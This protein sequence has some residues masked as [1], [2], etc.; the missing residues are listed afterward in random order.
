MQ[1]EA[2]FSFK[3]RLQDFLR[4]HQQGSSPLA[5]FFSGRP[6]VKDAMEAL[7]VPHLE[8]GLIHLNGRSVSFQ[9]PLTH[10]ALLEVIPVDWKAPSTGSQLQTAL[11]DPLIFLLDVHLGKLARQLRLLGFD[12]HYATHATD[13]ELADLAQKEQRIVLTRDVGLLKRKAIIWGYWLR[14]QDPKIQLLE[15]LAFL[16]IS[17]ISFRP[18]TR[19]MACN[20]LLQKVSKPSVRAHLQQKTERYF[21][22]FYQCT[23]CQKVYW[24]GSHYE[25]MEA[26]L[27]ELTVLRKD[28]E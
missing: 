5:Y 26:F 4:K 27:Q 7:G 2:A 6:S 17:K 22:E 13:A 21:D 25:K 28:G 14:S 10:G 1:Q 18:F 16:R 20:S 12:A 9:E 15:V 24:K 11:P 3:G 23:G 8:V 19:C